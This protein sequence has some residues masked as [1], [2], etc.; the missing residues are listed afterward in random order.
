MTFTFTHL[1][2]FDDLISP[3][4]LILKI[5]GTALLIADHTCGYNIFSCIKDIFKCVTFCFRVRLP[6]INPA[7]GRHRISQPMRIVVPIF[8]FPLASKNGLEA[9]FQHCSQ[10]SPGLPVSLHCPPLH[11]IVPS[12]QCHRSVVL[13]CVMFVLCLLHV[14]CVLV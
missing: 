5:D 2:K 8:L 3:N 14:C 7:Y 6:K 9:L 10:A 1:A 11:S 12:D 4:E 13:F